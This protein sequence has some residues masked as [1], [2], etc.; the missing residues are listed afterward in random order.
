MA[1]AVRKKYQGKVITYTVEC[2]KLDRT[3]DYMDFP[4]HND[5]NFDL[6]Q[7]HGA[8]IALKLSPRA[9]Y[10]GCF[11]KIDKKISMHFFWGEFC[12]SDTT[13]TNKKMLVSL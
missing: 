2:V 5:L 8:R 3:P 4:W 6:H 11:E 1:I 10:R 13:F 9:I 12:H 7:F